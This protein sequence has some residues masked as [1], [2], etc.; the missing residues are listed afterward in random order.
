MSPP[1][2]DAAPSNAAIS[3]QPLVQ[4]AAPGGPPQIGRAYDRYVIPKSAVA[5]SQ[6]WK[7]QDSDLIFG[8]REPT[9]AESSALAAEKSDFESAV[10]RFIVMIGDRPVTDYT[11][12]QVWWGNVLTPKAKAMVTAVLLKMLVPTDAEGESLFGS[13]TRV[14]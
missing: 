2:A 7:G 14:G 8:I 11:Q 5:E 10:P 1:P 4:P 9:G 3:T 13:R 6:H 12:V